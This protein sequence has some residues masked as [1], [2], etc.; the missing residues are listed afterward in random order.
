V[1]VKICDFGLA[2][3]QFRDSQ[4]M[5]VMIGSECVQCV[6]AVCVCVCVCSV[7]CSERV[8][9]LQRTCA[10]SAVGAAA[11][12]APT[13]PPPPPPLFSQPRRTWRPS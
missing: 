6:C 10:A 12:A 7:K 5:S 4:K 2:S 9:S 8:V 11:P 13:D 1:L 3:I